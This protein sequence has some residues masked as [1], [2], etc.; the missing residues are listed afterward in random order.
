VT[1][2]GL[3]M[4]SALCATGREGLDLAALGLLFA[5]LSAIKRCRLHTAGPGAMLPSR[6]FSAVFY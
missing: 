2:L 5:E 6:P 3:Q 4:F 1:A